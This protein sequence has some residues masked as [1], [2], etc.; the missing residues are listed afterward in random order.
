MISNM[1]T[2]DTSIW[3]NKLFAIMIAFIIVVFSA[4]AGYGLAYE[5]YNPNKTPTKNTPGYITAEEARNQV[6]GFYEQYLNPRKDTPEKSRK[7][8]VA[9]YGTKN[10][11]FYSE[12]YLHGFDPIMCSS[13]MPTSVVATK[14]QPGSGALVTAEATYPDGSTA[15]INLTL[16]LNSEGFGIDTITC[17]GEKG[18]LP[19]KN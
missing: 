14:V 9:S 7:A 10:L 11:V 5:K 6:N 1:K 18:N 12:Y 13:A 4:F 2:K 19:P 3:Q 8:Y 15:N 17:P 16:V